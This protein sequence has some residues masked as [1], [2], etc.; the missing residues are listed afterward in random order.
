MIGINSSIASLGQSSA[1]AQAGS[2]GLGFAIPI[3]EAVRVAQ[4]IES[5]TPVAHAQL[6]VSVA[7]SADPAG[8][9]VGDV[10]A[11]TAAAKAGLQSGDVVTKVG[12]Q[13]IDSADGL[14]A[15]IRTQAPGAKV[16]LTYVR[17]GETHTADVT[18]GTDQTTT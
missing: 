7:D 3:D 18:L 15:A 8:A 14:V 16:T 13:V 12:D 11:G 5:G 17:A 2:I 10:A 4:D 1:G 9:Q 6:G